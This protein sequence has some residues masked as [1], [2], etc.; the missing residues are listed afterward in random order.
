M[1][2]RLRLAAVCGPAPG[3]TARPP[4]PPAADPVTAVLAVAA[5]LRAGASPGRAWLRCWGI[6]APDGVPALTDVRARCGDDRHAAAVVAG[7]RLAA[8][9]GAPLAGVLERVGAA[10]AED[11]AVEVQR[12]AALAGPRATVQLLTWLPIVGVALGWS[13]GADPLAVLLD[14]RFGSALLLGAGLLTTAGWRWSARLLRAARTAGTAGPAS[15]AGSAGTAGP[16][17]ARPA[18]TAGPAGAARRPGAGGGVVTSGTGPVAEVDV[19][20]LLELL[21]AACS[22]GASVPLALDAV[23]DAAGGSRGSAL[24][25]AAAHLAAGATWAE[26]FAGADPTL[27]PVVLA[28]RPTW[29]DGVAPG[30]ALRATAAQL[31]RER[32]GA[33][34]AAAAR[35]GVRL[36]LPLAVCHLPAF[37]LVGLVPVL[38]SVGGATLR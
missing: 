3:G 10:L 18:G 38:V 32:Q 21:D 33:A 28:L 23:G 9:T 29:V 15:T 19:A 12:R 34:L 11:Q 16:A 36:V 2:G 22:A 6:S 4:D 17:A 5:A 25:A 20:V 30:G 14:G 1:S 13:L 27:A 35:L 37:V 31:R 7:A 8:R 24:M 26:A